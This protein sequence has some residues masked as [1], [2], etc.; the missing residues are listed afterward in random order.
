MI[1]PFGAAYHLLKDRQAPVPD[2]NVPPIR[3][4]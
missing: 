3:T 2:R 4:S 1:P